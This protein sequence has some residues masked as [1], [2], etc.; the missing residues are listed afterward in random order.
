MRHYRKAASILGS[1]TF[2]LFSQAS[3]AMPKKPLPQFHCMMLNQ[4]EDEMR[5]ASQTIYYRSAPNDS[6]STN[7][8][9]ESVIAVSD[10]A[11]ET[12]GYIPAV[13]FLNKQVW[14]KASAIRRY[15]A[16]SDPALRCQPAIRAD[17]KLGF[18]FS[19]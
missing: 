15:V 3:Y 11:K 16:V 19:H 7:G 2:G 14:I 8:P 12:N 13:N 1:L 18:I 5:D 6:A 9:A 17:G 10:S 4:T